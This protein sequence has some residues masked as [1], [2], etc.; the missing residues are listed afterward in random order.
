MT[1]DVNEMLRPK[2]DARLRQ[3]ASPA[4]GQRDAV[5]PPIQLWREGRDASKH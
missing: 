4:V 5:S 1:P 3:P 2:Q